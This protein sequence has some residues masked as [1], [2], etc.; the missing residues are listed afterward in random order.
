MSFTIPLPVLEAPKCLKRCQYETSP[1]KILHCFNGAFL[2]TFPAVFLKCFPIPQ[3]CAAKRPVS[4]TTMFLQPHLSIASRTSCIS[5]LPLY[6]WLLHS[7]R[8]IHR[9]WPSL[10]FSYL[11]LC[12]GNARV[13]QC[14]SR[15]RITMGHYSRQFRPLSCCF[16][17]FLTWFPVEVKPLVPGDTL[18]YCPAYQDTFG[19]YAK[20]GKCL[21]FWLGVHEYVTRLFQ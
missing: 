20:R 16:D 9:V 18:H 10:S 6:V 14:R 21:D 17:V 13:Y 4:I 7:A 15:F 1:Q 19:R 5:D 12:M 8:S 3:A 11:D 2:L